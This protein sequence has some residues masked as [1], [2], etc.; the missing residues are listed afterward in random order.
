MLK[1]VKSIFFNPDWLLDEVQ[2]LEREMG[3]NVLRISECMRQIFKSCVEEVGDLSKSRALRISIYKK[4]PREILSEVN[5][6]ANRKISKIALET[7]KDIDPSKKRNKIKT[8]QSEV[9]SNIDEANRDIYALL[10]KQ[11]SDWVNDIK[12]KFK[13]IIDGFSVTD[14]DNLKKCFDN[15]DKLERKLHHYEKWH[16]LFL[17]TTRIETISHVLGLLLI[18]L[19][20]YIA[21]VGSS[22]GA[23]GWVNVAASAVSYIST[24]LVSVSE[25]RTK[26]LEIIKIEMENIEDKCGYALPY[27]RMA[28]DITK[29]DK[30][31]KKNSDKLKNCKEKLRLRI[32]DKRKNKRGGIRFRKSP[33][34]SYQNI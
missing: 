19:S 30:D 14:V 29:N 21:S 13:K 20:G 6:L 25:Y 26:V 12:V 32:K 17:N 33:K 7:S 5:N 16:E 4:S 11:R 23:I 18:G 31:R 27:L 28:K 3:T 24:A 9:S 2:S 34:D 10:E 15:L 1:M 22:I 8:H